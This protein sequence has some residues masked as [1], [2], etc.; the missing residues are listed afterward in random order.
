MGR[1]VTPYYSRYIGG[2]RS[3]RN[4]LLSLSFSSPYSSAATLSPSRGRTAVPDRFRY[5][6]RS[7]TPSR[8]FRSSGGGSRP[9]TPTGQSSLRP[10]TPTSYGR[11]G[12]VSSGDY[13]PRYRHRSVS[14]SRYP[15]GRSAS[16]TRSRSVTPSGYRQGRS[17]ERSPMIVPSGYSTRS[18][19][20]AAW[21]D[22]QSRGRSDM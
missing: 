17:A 22:S 5:S 13:K 14:A 4:D 9:S 8:L 10:H 7:P 6:S 1:R 21:T 16:Y 20:P 12:R 11:A 15:M 18:P 3:K 19:S 2:H